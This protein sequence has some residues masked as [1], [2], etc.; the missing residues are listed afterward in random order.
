MPPSEQRPPTLEEVARRAGVGR[1]TASRVLNG[2]SQVSE[3]ARAKVMAAVDELGYVPNGA[4]RAL[5]TR[6]TESVALVVSESDER[7]FAEPF[8]ASIVRGVSTE[9]ATTRYRLLLSIVQSGQDR[10]RIE[11]YLTPQH[12]DGVLLLSLHGDDPLP[13]RLEERGLPA[14]LGGR[15]AGS[16]P[17]CFVD[18]DNEA[19]AVLAVEHLLACGRRRV[20]TVTGPQDM[21]AGVG[22]LAGWRRA[23][24]SHGIAADDELVEHGDFG[25]AS[26]ATAALALLERRPD[27]DAVFA[28]SDPMALGV[29]HTLAERGRSVP[30]DVAVVGFD[31]S[32]IARHSAP[33]LT[34]VHQPV[35]DMG[36]EMVRLLTARMSGTPTEPHVVLSPHLVVRASA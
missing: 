4:A 20:A 25:E 17:P 32:P 27:I 19:G 1:G 8:F 36:R 23:L 29:L 3:S 12:V 14:V 21:A 26:G 13:A 7:F 6:Q 18:V 22:R 10:R 31:D 11:T 5:V 24:T 9:L 16:D 30:G 33:P 28:A 15:P 34:T 2:A 35:E